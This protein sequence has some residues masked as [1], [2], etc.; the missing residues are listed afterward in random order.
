MSEASTPT[1][2]TAPTAAAEAAPPATV[3]SL[4]EKHLLLAKNTTMVKMVDPLSDFYKNLRGIARLF[5][6]EFS[7]CA[8]AAHS[9]QQIID[10]GNEEGSFKLSAFCSVFE[11]KMARH[12]KPDTRD[13]GV[14]KSISH[15]NVFCNMDF[16]EKVEAM[17]E[18]HKKEMLW[19][20]IERCRVASVLYLD[21]KNKYCPQWS[22][23]VQ[24][25]AKISSFLP[26]SGVSFDNIT[27]LLT[28]ILKSK[29]LVENDLAKSISDIMNDEEAS[30]HFFALLEMC[31]NGPISNIQREK[32]R[33]LMKMASFVFA[34][35][36]M[37]FVRRA[38]PVVLE[39]M[40]SFL[41]TK[42]NSLMKTIM[43]KFN[44]DEEIAEEDVLKM[45]EQVF[46]SENFEQ[47][48]ESVQ[49]S[50]TSEE[51]TEVVASLCKT[52]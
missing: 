37:N 19:G 40:A 50:L 4:R 14:L 39:K 43:D 38:G 24:F 42:E 18:A 34:P 29:T 12:M 5:V 21:P 7:E 10:M 41:D 45:G 3:E 23:M 44:A 52:E 31:T 36:Y 22:R 15:M 32:V 11:M 46:S 35:K 13:S 30:K 26:A 17:S 27:Q 2:T 1:P 47:L 25:C 51:M 49:N 8:F 9:L 20:C 48:K 16:M 33:K 28:D 6:H